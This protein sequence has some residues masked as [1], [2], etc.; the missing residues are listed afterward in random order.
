M[1]NLPSNSARRLNGGQALAEML[2]LHEVE[3]DPATVFE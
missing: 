1:T 3:F 2:R